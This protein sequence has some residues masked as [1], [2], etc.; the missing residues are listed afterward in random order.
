[1]RNRAGIDGSH[2]VRFWGGV[3]PDPGEHPPGERL[4]DAI[5]Q[6]VDRTTWRCGELEDWR[7]AGWE[8][9]C[10]RGPL[11]LDCRIT[12]S[13]PDDGWFLQ[14]ATPAKPGTLAMLF[15]KKARPQA[16]EGELLEVATT[17]A[18]YLATKQVE[19]RWRWNGHPEE[20][21]AP[22]PAEA[23]GPR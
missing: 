14:I 22:A 8:F 21:D 16:S 17:I 12:W 10:S 2:N 3:S 4:M 19:Q 11:T 5:R 23:E 1:M 18:G 9:S 13:G 7:D 6:A 15:G 20:G